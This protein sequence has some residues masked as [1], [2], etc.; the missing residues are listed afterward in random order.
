MK[1]EELEMFGAGLEMPK[2]AVK[3]Q[4]KIMLRALRRRFGL[5]GMLGIFKDTWVNQR[6]LRTDHPGTR[7]SAHHPARRRGA[8]E[9]C[10]TRGGHVDLQVRGLDAL[11]GGLTAQVHLARH[12]GSRLGRCGLR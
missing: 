12:P 9:W 7:V 2:E 6:R 11:E 8:H 10:R 4:G 3:A 5:V 1:V